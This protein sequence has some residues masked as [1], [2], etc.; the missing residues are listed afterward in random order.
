MSER[1]ALIDAAK[2][3][4]EA[5]LRHAAVCSNSPD[6]F[7]TV[8]EAGEVLV[9]AVNVYEQVLHAQTGWSNP[10]RHLGPIPGLDQDG[11]VEPTSHQRTTDVDQAIAV[12]V[13]VNY[14]LVVNEEAL[15]RFVQTR[16]SPDPKNAGEAVDLLFRSD[17]WDVGQYPPSIASLQS[18]E[19]Q[20][21]A[22]RPA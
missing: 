8:I 11:L 15:V 22:D 2:A 4:G 9:S 5:L 16:V 1:F 21:S 20:I 3:V 19:L 17:S 14:K 13:S 6:D 10:I 7:R 12:K 18:M